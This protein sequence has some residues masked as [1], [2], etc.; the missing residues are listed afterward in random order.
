M[1]RVESFTWAVARIQLTYS[2]GPLI[3]MQ[4]VTFPEEEPVPHR[5]PADARAGVPTLSTA[6]I[7]AATRAAASPIR[8]S[9]AKRGSAETDA[10]ISLLA[11]W[12]TSG[13]GCRPIQDE[14]PR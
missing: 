1:V 6:T 9:R 12:S 11:F 10:D 2:P 5:G 7:M 8:G 4:V 14:R 3:V 13:L